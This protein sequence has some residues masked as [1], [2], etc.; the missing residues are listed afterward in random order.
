MTDATTEVED[1]P[2]SSKKLLILSAIAA[3]VLGGG[4]F[5]VTYLGVFQGGA[6]EDVATVDDPYSA[7]HST[8]SIAF[9][10]MEQFVVSLRRDAE[11]RHLMFTAQLEV[12]SDQ[13]D[14]VI[15]LMPRIRDVLNTYLSAVE[16]SY[17]ERP[18]GL[19][20]LRGQMLR[21]AQIVTGSDMIRDLLVTEFVFN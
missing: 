7:S 2:K 10:P 20:Y 19:M 1:K 15:Y 13:K 11:N 17:I 12:Y 21:R 14:A 16:A 5:A 4:A 8:D 3:L 6:D 18:A 9:V